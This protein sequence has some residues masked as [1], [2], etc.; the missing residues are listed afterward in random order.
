[1]TQRYVAHLAGSNNGG[2]LM[3]K[4]NE[5]LRIIKQNELATNE[6]LDENT[7]LNDYCDRL[8][9]ALMFVG[10]DELFEGELH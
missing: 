5:A 1:M 9:S 10:L 3:T 6:L 2:K 4:L 8:E 7:E